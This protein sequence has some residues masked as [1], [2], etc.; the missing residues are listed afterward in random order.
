MS[1]FSVRTCE[2]VNVFIS[3]SCRAALVERRY[4]KGITVTDLKGKLE[5]VTGGNAAT[6][7]ISVFDKNDKLVCSLSNNEALLGSYPVDDGMRLHV[8]DNF[9]LRKQL[10]EEV[11]SSIQYKLSEEEY[12]KRPDSLLAYLKNNKLGKYNEDEMRK[13]EEEKRKE[14]EMEEERLKR[15]RIGDRC[16]VSVP[17]QPTRKATI[18]YT[19]SIKPKPGKWVGVKYDEPQGKNDGSIEGERYFECLPKYGG[20]VKALFV[21]V[22]EFPPDDDGLDDEL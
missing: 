12:A 7:S 22:G 5:L 21:E 2:F 11:D 19:G 1:E 15:I 13:K 6:M 3:T 20:F 10:E 9:V 14:E 17:G 4:H 18:M 8:E 16:K